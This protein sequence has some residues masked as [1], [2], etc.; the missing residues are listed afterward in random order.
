MS[1]VIA[2]INGHHARLRAPQQLSE[3]ERRAF[4]EAV[5]SVHHG[6]FEQSDLALLVEYSRL[7]VLIGQLWADLRSATEV[8]TKL[9]IQASITRNQKT[10]FAA[11]RLL[12]LAPS[13]RAPHVPSRESQRRSVSHQH[14]GPGSAYD[15]MEAI[16]E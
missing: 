14:R 15:A 8:E 7:V 13:T 2:A 1:N 9:A 3:E 10:L 4:G 12:R 6:H 11:C 5:A 16:D